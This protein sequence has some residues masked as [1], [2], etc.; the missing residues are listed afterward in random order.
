MMIR[1]AIYNLA[2]L[3]AVVTVL[4]ACGD[5]KTVCT[6]PDAPQAIDVGVSEMNTRN[7]V[8]D[9][10]DILSLGIFGYSTGAEPFD[11]AGTTYAHTPNLFENARATRTAG[12]EWVYDPVA[13]WPSDNTAKNT[14]FAYSPYM[15]DGSV[16]TDGYFEVPTV[17][18][19][20]PVIKYRVPENVSEQVD[21]LYSESNGDVTDINAT[22]NSS[23]VRYNMKHALLWIR[24]AIAT[25]QMVPGDPTMTGE[26]Y[27]I[28]E[29]RMIGGNIM[30]AGQFDLGTATWSPDPTAGMEGATYEFDYLAANPRIIGGGEL[31]KA[32]RLGALDSDNYLM[33]IPDDFKTDT[34]KISV[35]MSYTHNDGSAA[36]SPTEYFVTMPFPDVPLAGPGNMMVYVVKV[37]TNGAYIEFQEL[38]TIEEWVDNDTVSRPIEVY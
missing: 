27:T 5:D 9:A 36:P 23:K 20:A 22:T 29:F 32:V 1:K 21:L 10:G 7:Y 34:H 12:S 33:I 2:T 19:G 6:R 15:V 4:S 31:G 13:V 8:D 11:A 17:T 28:T 38:S 18:K 3:G 16:G 24:F 37:S 14:F 30:A 25:E 35:E 26:S